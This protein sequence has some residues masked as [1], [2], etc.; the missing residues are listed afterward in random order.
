MVLVWF[1]SHF[2]GEKGFRKDMAC[3]FRPETLNLVLRKPKFH[4][5]D[6]A[7]HVPTR[8]RFHSKAQR[9]QTSTIGCYSVV[10]L[11]KG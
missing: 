5:E 3:R 8:L 2:L 9:F 4:S 7:G 10:L 6:M 11:R 1:S